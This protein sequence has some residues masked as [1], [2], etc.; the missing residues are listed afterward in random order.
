M[1]GALTVDAQVVS[2]GL[3]VVGNLHSSTGTDIHINLLNGNG[4]DVTVGLPV[5]KQEIFSVSHKILFSTQERGHPAH[6]T[7][8]KF[9]VNKL[10]N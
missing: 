10:V 1:I 4:V 5:E 2:T 8:L 9:N 6:L 3:E 7:P